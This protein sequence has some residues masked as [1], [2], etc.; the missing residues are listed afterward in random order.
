MFLQA[1]VCPQVH[2]RTRYTPWA[3]TPPRPGTHPLSGTRYTPQTRYTLGPGTPP[4]QVHPQ[5][6]P[7]LG[8]S[9]PQT[10]YTPPL[11]DQVHPLD[12][13]PPGTRYTPWAGPPP[14]RSTPGQ[15]H[16][17][18][19]V[20]TPLSGTRYT[21]QTRYT[22]PT[23][24]IPPGRYTPLGRYTPQT[25][26]TP[27]GRY[28]PWARYTPLRAGTPTP[29]DQVSPL[30]TAEIWPLLWTVRILLE[31]ILVI[32]NVTFSYFLLLLQFE[33][34]IKISRLQKDLLDEEFIIIKR[35]ELL[36]HLFLN[37][38]SVIK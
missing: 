30:P 35:V 21:P 29:L 6:G 18:D 37:L 15:V 25:R 36:L 12:Q 17:P 11:W 14:G 20:H 5:A 38:P 23:R 8:R 2:S 26:Y 3:G 34:H 9:T 27:L 33:T 7:P 1:C 19:Q 31:C 4:G 32:F 13:V 10:R 22:P 28:T 16:P 24:H